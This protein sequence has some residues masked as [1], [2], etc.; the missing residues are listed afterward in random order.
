MFRFTSCLTMVVALCC[1]GQARADFV[2][3]GSEHLEVNSSHGRGDL[4]DSSTVDLLLGGSISRVHVQDEALLRFL[5]GT[6]S[7]LYVEGSVEVFGGCPGRYLISHVYSG[8]VIDILS[9]VFGRRTTVTGAGVVNIY[10]GTF[11]GSSYETCVSIGDSIN[12]NVYGGIFERGVSVSDA[13]EVVISGG[14]FSHRLSAGGTSSLD[15]S[16]GTFLGELIVADTSTLSISGGDFPVLIVGGSSDVFF[17]GYDFG[18]TDGLY[19]DGDKVLGSGTLTGKWE[20]GT[21]WAASI[22]YIGSSATIRIISEPLTALAWDNGSGDSNWATAANWNPEQVSGKYTEITIDNRDTVLL[23]S[24]GQEATEVNI[25]D[26]TLQVTNLGQLTVTKNVSVGTGGRLRVDGTLTAASVHCTGTLTGGGVIT[27]VPI[28]VKWG[29]TISPGNG[30]GTLSVDSVVLQ[31]GSAISVELSGLGLG[32]VCDQLD[33]AGELNLAAQGDALALNWVPA[34]PSSKFGGDYVV[35]TYGT[36]TGEFG[37]VGGGDNPY[38]IGTAY[39]ADVD[40]ET[41]DKITVSLHALLD[42]DADL[43]G[44]VWLSDWA[45]LRANF[46][47]TGTGKTW[48]DGNFDPWVDGKVWLSDWAALRANFSNSGLAASGAA[49]VPEPGTLVMLLG[50]VVGLVLLGWRRRR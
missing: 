26:G 31:S 19:L 4:N 45:A 1:A 35:A 48:A 36:R 34:G 50:G 17:Q 27:A 13:S 5:G 33:V 15:I 46:G 40:Y 14:T 28:A 42:G 7:Q 24:P 37:L 30:V 16:D 11:P 39:V 12:V 18:A 21:S 10:G 49:A 9:G 29:G 41:G 38:S 44:K 6:V 3:S 25:Q 2:L 22:P 43:D 20:D 47:N 8:G 23:D 32:G